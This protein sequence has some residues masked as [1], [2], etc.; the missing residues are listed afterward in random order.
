MNRM[1]T[2]NPPP[3]ST[4]G[5]SHP[6]LR[7]ML[8]PCVGLAMMAATSLASAQ[9]EERPLR[10][11]PCGNGPRVVECTQLTVREWP[12]DPTS[13]PLSLGVVRIRQDRTA[14]ATTATFLLVGGPGERA[15]DRTRGNLS[16][17]EAWAEYGDV[18]F[19]DQRGTEEGS[20]LRCAVDD[21]FDPF[22]GIF[23]IE[24][25]SRCRDTA[26]RVTDFAAY[27]TE[28]AAE[29]IEAAR[30][31]LGYGQIN[32]VAV[33]YG[34][35]LAMEYMERFPDRVRAAVLDG[36]VP[37]E[38]RAPLY[39][40]SDAEAALRRLSELCTT[41]E[42]CRIYGDPAARFRS[43]LSRLAATPA[44]VALSMPPS[45]TE[46]QVTVGPE[47]FAFAVRGLLYGDR[48]VELP[49]LLAEADSTG[50]LFAFARVYAQRVLGVARNFPQGLQLSVLCA[51]DV[52]TLTPGEIEEVAA[53][54]FAGSYL[55]DQYVAAC[56]KWRVPSARTHGA[57][58]RL[59]PPLLLLSGAM[60]PV[61]PPRWGDLVHA[62]SVNARHIVFPRGGHTFAGPGLADCKDRLVLEFL[63]TAQP[64][65]LDS[66]CVGSA[67]PRRFTP[68]A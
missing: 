3:R 24:S 40:V 44:T 9:S 46:R 56:G 51:E 23:P 17:Y 15:T 18:V 10:F 62:R 6:T 19:L 64:E 11:E 16:G 32:F 1:P 13:P 48:A 39:Y 54:T 66:T 22:T 43:V 59:A 68:P 20:P 29:D 61:T 33:S 41:D 35:R 37:R 5:T 4:L 52:A 31:A 58:S 7:T 65:A 47:H 53:T 49:R 34:T 26:A 28:N 30:A 27:G 14:P 63:R 38:L 45:F 55:I 50:E 8:Y 2:E 57:T 21:D 12:M 25:L 36:V 67:P 42:D 60:D